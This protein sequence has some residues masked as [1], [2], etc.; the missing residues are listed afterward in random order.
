MLLAANTSADILLAG[1]LDQSGIR[2][3]HPWIALLLQIFLA[4]V[5]CH[6][7]IVQPVL[8]VVHARPIV[9]GVVLVNT[10]VGVRRLLLDTFYLSFRLV[11]RA[12]RILLVIVLVVVFVIV[13]FGLNV[14]RSNHL[15]VVEDFLL[16]GGGRVLFLRGV[17]RVL[18]GVR[19]ALVHA[20]AFGGGSTARLIVLTHIF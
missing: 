13:D 14:V 6:S 2:A 17:V 20:L 10:A 19:H 7:R 18:F 11:L 9:R 16:L 15:I 4:G 5:S 12:R 8:W 1:L 3:G